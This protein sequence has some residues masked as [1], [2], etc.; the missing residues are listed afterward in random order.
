MKKKSRIDIKKYPETKPKD[1]KEYWVTTKFL[2]NWIKARYNPDCDAWFSIEE[3][4]WQI[5]V[6]YYVELPNM[7]DFERVKKRLERG[8]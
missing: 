4:P 5:V 8:K 1:L 7:F 2:H 3:K 6:D